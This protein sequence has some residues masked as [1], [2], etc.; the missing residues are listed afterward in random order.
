MFLGNTADES[1]CRI[2]GGG[3]V[4]NLSE[5]YM[6]RDCIPSTVYSNSVYWEN[7]TSFLAANRSVNTPCLAWCFWHSTFLLLLDILKKAAKHRDNWGLHLKW[8]YWTPGKSEKM[9]TDLVGQKGL[10][11][12]SD[13]NE[14]VVTDVKT[15]YCL[16]TLE[17]L[18]LRHTSMTQQ[19]ATKILRHSWL[20][21]LWNFQ[22]SSS[23]LFSTLPYYAEVA[24]VQ[25]LMKKFSFQKR[26]LFLYTGKGC[27]HFLFFWR[28]YV[29]GASLKTR[30]PVQQTQWRHKIHFV[31]YPPINCKRIRIIGRS[32]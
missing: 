27:R 32:L 3:R 14:K 2:Y 30:F 20:R 5:C 23:L 13:R 12:L 22:S 8:Y 7:I 9:A 17:T 26:W 18:N 31:A 25:R 6:S 28:T 21:L 4:K 1:P 15:D 24:L 11:I 16:I 19:T 10:L 29:L